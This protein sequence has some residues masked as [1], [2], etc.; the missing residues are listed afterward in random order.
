MTEYNSETEHREN[1]SGRYKRA[2]ALE[3]FTVGYNA[4]EAVVSIIA[5]RLA[6]S[7]ALVGFGLDSIVESL[8]GLVLIWRLRKH[9]SLSSEEEERVERRAERFVGITFFILGA[10]ILFEAVRKIVLTD[11]PDPSLFG[12][13]IAV[14]S[15]IIMPLLATAKKRLGERLGLRS[16]VADAKETFVCSVLSLALLLGLLGN[17]LFGFWLADPLVGIITV[18]YLVK[19]GWEL[20]FGDEEE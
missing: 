20:V 4:V 19:E 9:D 6:G 17:Y 13:I 5:G 10:Y 15:I 12:I 14:V 7:I 3:Y 18:G 8:S 1:E 2:L 16:L 11:I